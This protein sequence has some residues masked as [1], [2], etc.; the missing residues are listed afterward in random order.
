MLKSECSPARLLE[1]I[2]EVLENKS[3]GANG[4]K[5]T[6]SRKSLLGRLMGAMS[7]GS[8]SG[9]GSLA[10]AAEIAAS[11]KVQRDLEKGWQVDLA[12]IRQHCLGY[13]KSVGT[14]ESQKNLEDL[15]RSL[16]FLSA[17][18]AMG[19]C[20]KVSQLSPLTIMKGVTALDLRVA[21]ETKGARS[22][23]M[24]VRAA[25][26]SENNV[27]D[28]LAR[29]T[30]VTMA[31]SALQTGAFDEAE[32]GL[33]AGWQLAQAMGAQITIEGEGNREACLVLSLPLET[34]AQLS[35]VNEPAASSPS[36]KGNGNGKSKEPARQGQAVP[37]TTSDRG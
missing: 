29:L 27:Q 5:P 23:V 10:K 20:G 30:S 25:L 31:A 4:S 19:K 36:V 28:L 24:N 3:P 34:D 9:T 26:S 14:Q 32:L 37:N 18:A 15:Y 17:R 22:A 33:A 12:A 1:V 16:R 21:I 6:A 13:I 8:D 7:K 35:S 11:A 2:R